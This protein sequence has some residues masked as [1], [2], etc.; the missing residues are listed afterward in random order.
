MTSKTI[1][2]KP[3]YDGPGRDLRF[4]PADPAAARTL[5]AEQ[6]QHFNTRGYVP[7]LD[8]FPREEALLLQSYV[9]DLLREVL[10]ADDRR[11]SYSIN[12]YHHVCRGLYDVVSAPRILD[13]V[14]DILGEELVCWGSHLFAKLPGDG[15][16][17]PFHQ[18]AIYWPLTPTRS[19]T[20]W[21]A[22]DDVDAGN[23]AMQFVPG[24]H[25]DG[26]IAHED[27]GLDGT[28][29]L[30]RRALGMEARPERYVDEL[31]AGQASL[32][33][34]LLLHGSE[35][36]TSDRR[37][38]GFTIRFASASVRLVDGYEFWQKGSMHMRKG[39]PSGFWADR[40]GPEGEHPEKM[41]SF[42]GDF[43]GQS[44]DAS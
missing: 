23:A 37:R 40:P 22:I 34:D 19:V 15:K 13:L 41:A 9:G 5:T 7:S 17:V 2:R 42:Y 12:A 21:L 20:L 39:D 31:Q 8:V 33:S 11:N 1:E 28:R 27:V 43:D 26:A 24:S 36:N 18:D 29:V 32:H 14:Q 16:E 38:A 6:V 25:L 35:A 44:I 3:D 10:E 4:I 30:G